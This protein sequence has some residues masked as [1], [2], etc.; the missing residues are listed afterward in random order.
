[1]E[2]EAQLFCGV[3]KWDEEADVAGDF[4]GSYMT[5]DRRD[6]SGRRMVPRRTDDDRRAD[7]RRAQ[8]MWVSADRRSGLDR[9]GS[10]DRREVNDR[11]ALPDRRMR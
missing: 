6:R 8:N 5:N 11:R 3:R 1:M 9:R 10:D 4:S 7:E 2:A